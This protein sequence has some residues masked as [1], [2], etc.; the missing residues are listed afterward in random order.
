MVHAAMLAYAE[1]ADQSSDLLVL[2]L[3]SIGVIAG[4]AVAA[5][6]PMF[7]VT[8]RR[9]MRPHV[10][11]PVCLLWAV[12]AGGGWLYLLFA[13]YRWTGEYQKLVMS[14][15]YDP[16]NTATRPGVNP[17]FLLVLVAGYAGLMAVALTARQHASPAPR[18]EQVS[19]HRKPPQHTTNGHTRGRG[20]WACAVPVGLGAGPMEENFAT[21][22]KSWPSR[23]WPVTWT[24][25]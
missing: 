24:F 11:A 7:V 6:V 21:S 20:Y 10:L 17:V 14:G 18:E 1:G 16:A 15:F 5:A 22:A 13:R 3:E 9:A 25:M 23:M 12:V 8:G 19:L 2:I 4:V